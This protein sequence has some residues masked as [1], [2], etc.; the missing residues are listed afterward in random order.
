VRAAGV[1]LEPRAGLAAL[2]VVLTASGALLPWVARGA[3]ASLTAVALRG[4]IWVFGVL[5]HLPFLTWHAGS[6]FA[7]ALNPEGFVPAE[8]EDPFERARAAERRGDVS[9]AVERY[10]ALL[11][12]RPLHVE[13]RLALAEL[14]AGTRR[15]AQAIEVVEEGI[16]LARGAASREL[17]ARLEEA[18]AKFRDGAGQ[19][20]PGA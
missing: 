15:R 5:L 14:L 17:E 19:A 9:G 16:R 12:E 10:R 13:A 8:P 6:V 4:G 11:R 2:V 18:L 1:W 7:S 3:Q 20:I